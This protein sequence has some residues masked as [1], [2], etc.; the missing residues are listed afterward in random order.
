MAT[1]KIK[2][3]AGSNEF[4]AEG[5][6]EAVDALLAKWWGPTKHHGFTHRENARE[7]EPNRSTSGADEPDT[8]G[9][10]ATA[11]ANSLKENAQFPLLNK[12]II[13]AKGEYYNKIAM[14]LWYYNKAM[15]SGEIHK[16]L[17]CL[18]VKITLPNLSNTIS[19]NNS[20]FLHEG[21]RKRGGSQTRYRLTASAIAQFEEL[22]GSMDA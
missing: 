8:S 18:S 16:V 19:R 10:D 6:M 1:V 15:T 22:L 13:L 21:Q 3:K 7:I 9:F 17:T 20:K 4:E 2:L 5:T 11:V 14:V 12:K